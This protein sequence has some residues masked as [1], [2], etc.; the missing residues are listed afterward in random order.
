MAK[1]DDKPKRKGRSCR[2]L[3]CKAN[4]DGNP[5]SRVVS[6]PKDPVERARWME[7]MPN[8]REQLEKLK[9]IWIC[10][11]HFDCP[12]VKCQGG[13]RPAGPPTIFDGISPSSFKQVISKPRTEGQ[14]T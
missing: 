2:V 8:N 7:A 4:Y 10:R 6:F 1:P 5:Y 14:E 13:E 12:F 3:G 9:E 11:R